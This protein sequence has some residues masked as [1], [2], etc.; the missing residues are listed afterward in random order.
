MSEVSGDL[1]YVPTYTL[2]DPK[3]GMNCCHDFSNLKCRKV[4]M[5]LH[6]KI[7]KV[8]LGIYPVETNS[9]YWAQHPNIKLFLKNI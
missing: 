5:Q 7:T 8:P 1:G 2:A 3:T 4:H 9:F 6:V